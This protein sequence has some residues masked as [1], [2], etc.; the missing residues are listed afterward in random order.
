[1]THA[2][3]LK[4]RLPRGATL[5]L[6]N[7]T[8]FEVFVRRSR[9][10]ER[11]YLVHLDLHLAGLYP[12]PNRGLDGLCQLGLL[13]VRSGAKSGTCEGQA[14]QQELRQVQLQISAAE[15]GLADRQV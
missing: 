15:S 11:E 2:T 7:D 8:G 14:L 3:Y 9:L 1:M 10:R 12:R 5:Y 6:Q 4:L 13:V